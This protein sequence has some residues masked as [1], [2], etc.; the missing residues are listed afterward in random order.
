MIIIV[1]VIIVIVIIVI[2]YIIIKIIINNNNNKNKKKNTYATVALDGNLLICYGLSESYCL[3]TLVSCRFHEPVKRSPY[4][5]LLRSN[6]E[7][8]VYQKS[9]K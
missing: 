8:P 1:I 7:A 3:L 9:C 2:I 4:Q 6:L 5:Q